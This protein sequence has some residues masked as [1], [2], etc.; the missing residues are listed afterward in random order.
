MGPP[1][2]FV[3]I[4]G[5]LT[6]PRRIR[7]TLS[8]LMPL[9]GNHWRRPLG[10]YASAAY[11][12]EAIE[13]TS[14]VRNE[15][16]QRLQLCVERTALRAGYTSAQAADAASQLK[17]TP[18]LQTGPHC[19]LLVEPDAFNTHL[20]SLM[21]LGAHR[22]RWHI[23]YG[24]S[25]VKLI[26]SA[27]KGPGWLRFGD[28]AINVFG[29]ARKQMDAYSLCGL[30]K[31]PFSFRPSFG[32]QGG[33]STPSIDTFFELLPKTEFANAASAIKAANQTLWHEFSPRD[34]GLVQLDDFDVG[35]LLADHL[36]DETSW[37]SRHL[38]GSD[39]WAIA[40]LESI[41][42]LNTGDW[43]GW[44]T[45]TTD[46]F[47]HQTDARLYPLRL[48]GQLLSCER[49]PELSISFDRRSVATALRNRL[50]VPNLLIT[51]LLTSIL[52]GVRVLGG[53][54]QVVYYPLMRCVAAHAFQALHQGE[55][56][57]AM[58]NDVAPGLWGHRVLNPDRNPFE[59]LRQKTVSQLVAQYSV[60]SLGAA[61]GNLSSFT[62]DKIW[63][64]MVSLV[65]ARKI[66]SNSPQWHWAN[67]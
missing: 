23:W 34:Y 55:I 41:R 60:Q 48:R 33:R 53:C 24:A 62:R 11:S 3:P 31:R 2:T 8:H 9:L 47:W 4:A 20:F 36:E 15:A 56:L 30:P 65:A 52:P 64:E 17:T 42:Q 1:A 58:S 32:E 43:K 46:L 13:Q 45:Q 44:I 39:G 26:E 21:G 40:A 25:T 27:K 35:D 16:M 10:D 29:L 51:F 5:P 28:Q 18:V 12:V 66:S 63:D 49:K 50:I 61:S 38:F 67:L 59:Q 22:L 7:A 57:G 14:V 6:S 54:R 37:L 19:H